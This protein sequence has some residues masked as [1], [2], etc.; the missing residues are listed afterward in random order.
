MAK[1]YKRKDS[2]FWWIAPTIN[3]V[4]VPQSSGET[5]YDRA[6]RA[7]RILEGKIAANAPITPKT[8]RGSFAALLESVEVDYTIMR[9]DTLPDLKRRIEKHLEPA[10]GH[11]QSGKVSSIVI[12]R[13]VLE[14]QAGKAENATIN[15]ELA[16][17]KRAFKL[18]LRD[19]SV[20]H[21]P[22]IEMLPEDNVRAGFFSPEAFQSLLRFSN[23]LLRQI[24]TVAWFTGWR[25]ESVI[26]L[27]WRNV[28]LSRGLVGLT[29]QQTKNGK[30][31]AF[32]LDPFPELRSV[33]EARLAETK[34]VE[35]AK[36][37]RIPYVF[38]REGERIKSIRTAFV[39]ARQR[40][41]LPGRTFHDFRRTAAMNLEAM[42]FSETEI[43]NMIG[44][45]T[46]AMFTRYNIT[47]ED[48]ILAK[49]KRIAEAQAIRKT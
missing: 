46:L 21:I 10:L 20:S 43:M 47:N 26:L 42:G 2:R 32:P 29:R 1:P 28:D 18:G 4:Q 6:D 11:I 15:R 39:G 9:R 25:L 44:L 14:R 34:T 37:M 16:I 7:L 45:K 17:I 23:P 30:A 48:R 41:G 13:Y 24:V 27:E 19:G 8:N 33:L 49:G 35:R 31:T 22:H 36:N 38:H 40:A 3:G 5:D 12:S